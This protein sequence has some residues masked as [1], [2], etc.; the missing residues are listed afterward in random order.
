MGISTYLSYVCDKQ[1]IINVPEFLRLAKTL[2]VKG[3]HLHN[4]LPHFDDDENAKFW[5]MV[6]TKDDLPLIQSIAEL[7]EAGIIETYPILIS[8]DE[9]RKN[10]QFPWK[11]IGI[12]GN[13]SITICNSVSPPRRENG[14]ISD[15]VIW[16]NSY[17]QKF[18]EMKAGEQHETCKKC[19]RNW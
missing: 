17:C 2:G 14:T 12:N 19:F 16:Q 5:D 3:V 1:S 18:R 6:L 7:P 11:T 4:L 8:K 15:Y 9:T 13:G 10:C